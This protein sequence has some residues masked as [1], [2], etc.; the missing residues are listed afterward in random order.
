MDTDAVQ[1]EATL[2]DSLAPAR[3]RGTWRPRDETTHAFLE[4]SIRRCRAGLLSV[5]IAIFLYAAELAYIV[6]STQRLESAD[7]SELITSRGFVLAGW[8]GAP[9]YVG[10]QWWHATVQRGR[11]ARLQKLQAD[12]AAAP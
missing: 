5:P 10:G 1:P 7:W 12:L 6:V 11:L 3:S 2:T 8:I 9:L 4:V